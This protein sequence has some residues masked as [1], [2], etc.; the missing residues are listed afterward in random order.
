[1]HKKVLYLE[2][3]VYRGASM[4]YWSNALKHPKAQLHGFDSFEGLPEDWCYS[5]G[6]GAFNVGGQVPKMDD[7]RVR[8]FKGWFQ[9]TLPSYQP[10]E[11]EVLVVN[12]DADLYSSTIYVLRRLRP[13]IRPGTFLYFDDMGQPEHEPKALFEFLNEGGL[14]L[15]VVCAD[16]SL[17]NIFFECFEAVG[18]ARRAPSSAALCR[19]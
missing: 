16:Y 17:N 13:H 7:P 10:P 6:K 3:G 11:H 9:E 14:A 15:R 8:L 18:V 12:M 1:M 19:S 2:F 4:R 5:R